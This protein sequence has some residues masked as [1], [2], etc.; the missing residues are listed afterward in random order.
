MALGPGKSRVSKP[1][2]APSRDIKPT[3]ARAPKPSP[4]PPGACDTHVHVFRPDLYPYSADRAYTPGKVTSKDLSRFLDRHDL[5][6][7]VI[8]QP[9]VY[10][11]DNRA[12]LDAIRD[13]KG[14]ARGIA[15][16]DLKTI[17]DKELSRLDKAGIAGIRLNVATSGE[18]NLARAAKRAAER[19][20]GTD[21]LIQIYAP[22]ADIVSARR[23]LTRLDCAIVL[24]HFGGAVLG[25]PNLAK[26]MKALV[27]LATNGPAVLK[28]S[29]PY[30][31]VPVKGHEAKRWDAVA[32]SAEALLEAPHDRLIWGSDWPHTAS[33]HGRKKRPNRIEPFQQIDDKHS[34]RLAREWLA[35]DKL[36]RRVLVTNPARLYGFPKRP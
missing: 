19:L 31:V 3:P 14:R 29:A 15:V 5:D 6:R 28:L 4:L 26:G 22:L 9:S 11:T 18:G 35:D 24:D 8:I 21:W 7:V 17:T 30:R 13:L 16:V 36:L 2:P 23:T 27:D 32:P 10:G 12:M 34:I 20:A 33:H 1:T 25:Q